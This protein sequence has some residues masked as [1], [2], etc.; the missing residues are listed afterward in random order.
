MHRFEKSPTVF[1]QLGQRCLVAELDRF[2]L[3]GA[4]RC[5]VRKAA[6]MGRTSKADRFA[7]AKR[8]EKASACSARYDGVGAGSTEVGRGRSLS[9][10]SEKICV[11]TGTMLQIDP[12]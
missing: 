2:V 7:G 8:K 4:A 6:R 9:R 1:A 12:P 10:L 11:S 3:L 5:L